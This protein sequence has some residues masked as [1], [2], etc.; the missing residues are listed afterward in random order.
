MR[1]PC[2]YAPDMY[3]NL[4]PDHAKALEALVKRI[5]DRSH[6]KHKAKVDSIYSFTCK[7]Y[8]PWQFWDRRLFLMIFKIKL[9]I[10]LVIMFLI[11]VKS[12]W[13]FA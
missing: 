8:L 10:F 3:A 4:S 9:C 7:Y 1:G 12:V 2:P 6:I 5:D 13:I 11:L